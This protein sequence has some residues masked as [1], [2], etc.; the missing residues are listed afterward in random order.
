MPQQNITQT[1][2][3]INTSLNVVLFLT[4][5]EFKEI[6]LNNLYMLGSKYLCFH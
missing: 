5:I 4:F 3:L 2:D 6:K 1:M